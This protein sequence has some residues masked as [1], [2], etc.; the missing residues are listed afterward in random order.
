MRRLNVQKGWAEG[1]ADDV[2]GVEVRSKAGEALYTASGTPYYGRD[3]ARVA[4]ETVPKVR[5]VIRCC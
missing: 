4:S 1:K 5:L 3:L 2:D